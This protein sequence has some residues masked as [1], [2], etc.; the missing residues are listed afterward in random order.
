MKAAVERIE[1]YAGLPIQETAAGIKASGKTF[2]MLVR[3]MYL[4]PVKAPVREIIHNHLD[5]HKRLRLDRPV[6][7]TMPT[8]FEPTWRSRDF[9][10]SMDHLF[11]MDGFM[12]LGESR[13]EGDHSQAGYWGV[14][15]K[16]PLAYTD[17]FNV[18]C[19]QDRYFRLYLVKF[20]TFDYPDG[21][22]DTRPVIAFIEEGITAEPDGTE[23]SWAVASKDVGRFER[24]G[25]RDACRH[26][27]LHAADRHRQW[28]TD[29][30]VQPH[31]PGAAAGP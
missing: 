24:V 15:S 10:E 3:S 23:V 12:T 5:E 6:E 30:P 28:L 16:S 17:Q 25:H 4:N 18:R 8:I 13:K 9:G 26:V 20:K 27:R 29:R 2:K 22:Y 31:G 1:E 19:I 7:I 21:S 11:M 14:G